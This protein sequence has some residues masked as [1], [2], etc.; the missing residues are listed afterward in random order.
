M[1]QSCFS[2][3]LS[4]GALSLAQQIDRRRTLKFV[5]SSKTKNTE[6]MEGAAP[7]RRFDACIYTACLCMLCYSTTSADFVIN[8][9]LKA[10]ND[11]DG[12]YSA[13]KEA[14]SV[15][16][17]HRRV[18]I[19]LPAGTFDISSYPLSI[20]PSPHGLPDH[21]PHA[22]MKTGSVDVIVR[23]S[24][25]GNTTLRLLPDARALSVLTAHSWGTCD[26]VTIEDLTVLVSHGNRE[27]VG[28]DFKGPCTIRLLALLFY[29]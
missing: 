8:P 29:P 14:T 9:V 17:L 1:R 15:Y 20:A 25:L 22:I 28:I 23:G 18:V 7:A 11:V 4:R 10:P 5:R 12:V 2:V 21:G 13:F 6:P 26:S 24:S 3:P 19:Q 27:A 16:G